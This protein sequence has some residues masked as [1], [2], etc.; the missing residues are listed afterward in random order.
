MEHSKEP[1]GIEPI[2]MYTIRDAA[3][4][5][6]MCF[7]ARERELDAANVRRIVAAVNACAGIPTEVL[8]QGIEAVMR[9][10]EVEM[11]Y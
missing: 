9:W 5:I 10:L 11:E 2:G 8:E 4:P 3:G 1:W 7:S 6:A